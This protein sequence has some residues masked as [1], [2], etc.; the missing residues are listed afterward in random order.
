MKI[1]R[2]VA[3]VLLLNFVNALG[4]SVIFPVLPFIIQQYDASPLIYGFLVSSY[5]FFQFLGAPILGSL[6][7]KYGRRPILLISQAGTMIS[8]AI[9]GLAYFLPSVPILFT[10]LPIIVLSLARV[11]DGITGGNISVANAYLADVTAP[12]E[13]TKIFGISGAIFGLA[14][15]IGPVIGGFS[16]STAIGWLGTTIVAFAISLFT[17]TAMYFFLPESLKEEDKDKELKINLKKELNIFYKINK[18]GD[19]S[20]KPL[21][22]VRIFFA[23]AFSSYTSILTLYAQNRYDLDTKALGFV[24]L[25][26]GLFLVVNQGLLVKRISDKLGNLRTYYLGQAIFFIGLIALVFAD[27]IYLFLIISYINNLGV[28][29]SLPSF[30]ALITSKVDKQKQGLVNGVDESMFSISS[31]FAPIIAAFFYGLQSYNVTVLIALLLLGQFLVTYI[32]SRKFL[33][34][35]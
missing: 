18:L 26:I 8:W 14:F 10:T 30:K 12:K 32:W 9:F 5:A 33:L 2:E 24:F 20:F 19:K 11:V 15:I 23:L 17:L 34:S 21:F 29:L 22:S 16:S 35:E 3:P 4:F 25:T 27:N 1:K 6:S 7:D 31:A 13:R 28:S